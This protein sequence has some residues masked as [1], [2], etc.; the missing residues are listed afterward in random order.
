MTNSFQSRCPRSRG[1]SKSRSGVAA[2]EFAVCLPLVVTLIFASIEASSMIFLKLSLQTSAYEAARVASAPNGSSAEAVNRGNN[3]LSQHNVKRG[4]IQINPEDVQS[5]ETGG[6]I[7]V[8]AIAP[9]G[10]NR[11]IGKWFFNPG[12]LTATCVMVKEGN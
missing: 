12:D 11:L 3:A 5:V 10:A 4:T 1:G 6:Q 8:S 9:V 2:V 7:T